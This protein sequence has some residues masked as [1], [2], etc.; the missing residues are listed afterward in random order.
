VKTFLPAAEELK[1]Q[2]VVV[3]AAGVVLGRL[4]S[5]IAMMLRGKHRP[6]YTPHIDTGDGVIVI[7]AAKVRLTGRKTQLEF[8]YRHSGFPGGFRKTLVGDILKTKPEQLVTEA[9]WGMLPKTKL[10]R[11]MLT[12]LKVYRAAEHP[13]SAQKPAKVEIAK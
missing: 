3:D 12:R 8:R 11:R 2:W 4:A 6:T 10:G 13:H 9:V 1:R 7:N 5:R